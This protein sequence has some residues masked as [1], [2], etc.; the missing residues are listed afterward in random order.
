M[1]LPRPGTDG[2]RLTGGLGGGSADAGTGLQDFGTGHKIGDEMRIEQ[3]FGVARGTPS[4]WRI[5]YYNIQ[6]DHFSWIADRSTDGGKTWAKDY[7][8]IE[9]R[10]LGPARTLPSFA[11]ARNRAGGGTGGT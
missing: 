4:Q 6:P 1:A 5:R 10:R 3:T 9:A 8:K 11:P 2:H 7:Q